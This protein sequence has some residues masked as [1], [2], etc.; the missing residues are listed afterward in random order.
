MLRYAVVEISGRQYLVEPDGKISVDLLKEKETFESDKVLLIAEGDKV[1]LGSPFLKDKLKFKVLGSRRDPKIRV[2][3]YKPKANYRR[4][5]GSIRE[6]T[7]IQ[8]T[9]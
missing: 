3:T 4:V 2:S 7:Q 8:L 1:T 5:K 9:G 6:T